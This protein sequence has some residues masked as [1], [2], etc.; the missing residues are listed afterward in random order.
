[1][2]C[3]LQAIPL[4]AFKPKLK[5][6][7]FTESRGLHRDVTVE[8]LHRR[9]ASYKIEDILYNKYNID[10]KYLLPP[11]LREGDSDSPARDDHFL[12]IELFDNEDY[13]TR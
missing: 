11:V 1:M 10:L 4:K 5:F 7:D 12:P 3:L 8:Q 6:T 13:D 9:Y 2:L